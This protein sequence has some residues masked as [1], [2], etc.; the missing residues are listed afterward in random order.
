L[1]QFLEDHD[2][3]FR[4]RRLRHAIARLNA[5]REEP[6]RLAPADT[7][8]AREAAWRALS[9]ALET[10]PLEIDEPERVLEAPGCLLREIAVADGLPGLDAQMEA[11]LAQ[12]MGRLADRA[13]RVLLMAWLGFGFHDAATLALTRDNGLAET[14]PVQIDRISPSMPA[15]MASLTALA[16][17]AA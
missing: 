12:A 10:Q 16:L 11:V 6:G 2:I 17:R 9:L 3:A 7:A 4:Q 13:A 5:A 8:T 14:S 15:A 1:A